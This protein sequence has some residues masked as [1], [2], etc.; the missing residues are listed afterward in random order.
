M[1]AAAQT[2]RGGLAAVGDMLEQ[3][4]TNGNSSVQTDQ[5]E[6]IRASYDGS[7]TSVSPYEKVVLNI[8]LR[9]DSQKIAPFMR[10]VE[11]Y[12]WFKL[13]FC[14]DQHTCT[15]VLE[16][17]QR[18]VSNYYSGLLNTRSSGDVCVPSLSIVLTHLL[19]FFRSKHM[20]DGTLTKKAEARCF[21]SWFSSCHSYFQME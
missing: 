12:M 7:D 19:F 4:L 8:L 14:A 6:R 11:D 1:R 9:F 5:A 13:S 10:T 15:S 3:R 17:L 16:N 2:S 20:E 21:M 18:D